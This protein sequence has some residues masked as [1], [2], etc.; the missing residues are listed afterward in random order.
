MLVL[1][2]QEKLVIKEPSNL[3]YLAIIK[4]PIVLLTKAI[5]DEAYNFGRK[6]GYVD[7]GKYLSKE[8]LLLKQEENDEIAYIQSRIDGIFDKIQ[9]KNKTLES[10]NLV[11]ENAVSGAL[12]NF[13]S[14]RI[15]F[16]KCNKPYNVLE[17]F[18]R[19]GRL[20]GYKEA[21]LLAKEVLKSEK[22]KFTKLKNGKYDILRSAELILNRIDKE[23]TKEYH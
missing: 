2:S 5:T 10:R 4:M 6:E 8:L 1:N 13:H 23:L 3:G 22:E 7:S 16:L 15:R 11:P 17:D 21:R 14:E 12:V 18:R 19:K 20:Q 9:E